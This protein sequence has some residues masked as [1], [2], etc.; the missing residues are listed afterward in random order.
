MG[1]FQR[2]LVLAKDLSD[3]TISEGKACIGPFPRI[4][5]VRHGK[6][7]REELTDI[8]NSQE[9]LFPMWEGLT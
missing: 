4:A 1:Y 7:R 6:W 8:A 5:L 3:R 2:M 9:V